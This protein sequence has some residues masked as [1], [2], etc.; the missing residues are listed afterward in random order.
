MEQD[1]V[2][3]WGG[4]LVHLLQM[5]KGM[6]YVLV[7]DTKTPVVHPKRLEKVTLGVWIRH[8]MCKMY[9]IQAT[10]NIFE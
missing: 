6:L 4:V 2:D 8:N 5:Q 3:V 9:N 1:K 7:M 10:F